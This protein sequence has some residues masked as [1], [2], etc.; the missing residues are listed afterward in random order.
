MFAVCLGLG[1]GS[2][3][4]LIASAAETR[5]AHSTVPVR[6]PAAMPGALPDTPAP[7]SPA[8]QSTERM[9]LPTS[10]GLRAPTGQCVYPGQAVVLPIHLDA[11][12]GSQ[13]WFIEVQG[14][15]IALQLLSQ[16]KRQTRFLLPSDSRI[17]PQ[18]IYPVFRQRDQW[19]QAQ[20]MAV[21]IRTCTF[22]PVAAPQPATGHSAGE[23][24]L[25]MDSALLDQVSAEIE[26]QDYRLVALHSL[27]TLGQSLLVI[28]TDSQPL[29]EA[30]EHLRRRF[31]FAEID[32]NDHYQN[33]SAPR[34]YARE[35]INWPPS[36]DCQTSGAAPLRIGLIDGDVALDHPDL[37]GQRITLQAFHRNRPGGD[38]AHATAIAV[39]LVGNGRSAALGGLLPDAELIAASVLEQFDHGSVATTEAMARALDWLLAQQVR[40]VNISLSGSRTN[41]VLNRILELGSHQGLLIFAAAG[42]DKLQNDVAFPAGH[43]AV[44]AITAI[45][46]ANRVYSFANQ[47]DYLDFSA[48]G[49]DIWTAS[50]GE[51]GQY[52]SGTSFATPY[53]VAVA[54][55]Y[56]R[57]NP[58]MSRAILYNVMQGYSQDLGATGH[59]PVFGWGK[60]RLPD[61]MCR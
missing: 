32:R 49:V 43:P 40:L 19:S 55:L 56:L 9:P 41:S 44:I 7:A 59:D 30:I 47:G 39:L 58:N 29:N 31:P 4:S 36:P 27:M 5:P 34:Q 37:L 46:A 6:D 52:R 54:A 60:L 42:N 18:Q 23:I 11:Q 10:P 35:K 57:L 53:A 2:G 21:D 33:A 28:K 51:D 45:D 12:T 14:E 22:A 38:Q 3:V 25:L 17:K 16:D 26:R 1:W 24:V 48:P 8:R 20:P 15:L 13:Q 61:E 50:P